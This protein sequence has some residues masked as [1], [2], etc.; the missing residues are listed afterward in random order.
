MG[1][2]YELISVI[3]RLLGAKVGKRVY[4]PGSGLDIVEY[5]LLEVGDDVVFGSRSTVLTSTASRSTFAHP[6]I[7][8]PPP[9]F[10]DRRCHQI[11]RAHV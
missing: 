11:G 8:S 1:T 2:H 9:H 10:D 7:E 4:W 5:D 6:R 3:Y